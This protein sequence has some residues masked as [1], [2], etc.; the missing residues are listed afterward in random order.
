VT[1]L[2]AIN[3]PNQNNDTN[4]QTINNLTKEEILE[5]NASQWYI[6]LQ[7]SRARAKMK[8]VSFMKNLE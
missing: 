4:E 7:G 1:F 6:L 3:P 8:S 5:T 2:T